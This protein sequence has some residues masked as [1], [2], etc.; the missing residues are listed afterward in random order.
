MTMTDPIADMLTR[1]RNG[2]VAAQDVVRMPSSK[3]KEALAAILRQEGYIAD[4]RLGDDANRPGRMLEIT[5][6]Y[7]PDRVPTITGLR[8]VSK[9][10]LRVYTKADRLPRVLGGLGVAVL[11]TSHGLMTDRE[12]RD[13]RVGGE[14][15]CYVW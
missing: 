4:F 8:R 3:L 11:S 13:R 10:G 5:L 14:V 12:A 15:L 1:L 2:S 7:T 6:K 9:P